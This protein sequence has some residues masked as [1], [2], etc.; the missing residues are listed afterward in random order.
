[1]LSTP[2]HL[3]RRVVPNYEVAERLAYARAALRHITRSEIEDRPII[4][5]LRNLRAHLKMEMAMLP[6][7]QVRVLFL[8]SDYRLL[9]EHILT[10]GGVDSV[11]LNSRTIFSLAI[12]IGATGV[13]LIHNHPSGD[14]SPSIADRAATVRLAT[15]LKAID[16]ILHDHLIVSRSGLTSLRARGIM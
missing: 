9:L 5:G 6:Y 15:G 1:M 3:I 7:E 14:A 13:I 8:N 11:A 10:E 12:D 4:S 16:V 2:R